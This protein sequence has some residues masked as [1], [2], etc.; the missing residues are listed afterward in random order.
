[1]NLS[2]ARTSR[3]TFWLLLLSL[4]LLLEATMLS[5]RGNSWGGGASDETEAKREVFD[6]RVLLSWGGDDECR[7]WDKVEGAF[8]GVVVKVKCGEEGEEGEE[9]EEEV[10]GTGSSAPPN[11]SPGGG[12]SALRAPLCG[13]RCRYCL[14]PHSWRRVF[15]HVW[16]VGCGSAPKER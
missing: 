10:L 7:W 6:I 9:K 14:K 5:I 1:M 15:P 13:G 2:T 3:F 8:E 4:L 11:D 12:G 16:L